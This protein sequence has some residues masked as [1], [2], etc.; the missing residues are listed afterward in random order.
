MPQQVR[1]QVTQQAGNQQAGKQDPSPAD[2]WQPRTALQLVAD[3]LAGVEAF[4]QSRRIAEQAA[5]AADLAVVSREARLDLSRRMT[6]LHREREALLAR[7]AQQMRDSA[8]Q[9]GGRHRA[10]ALLAHRNEW[11]RGKVADSLHSRGVAVVAGVD[12]GADAVG[13]M[14]MEQPDLVFLED[15]LPTMTG[16]EVL[17]QAA[18]LVPHARVVAQ[19][20]DL[21]DARLYLAAGA[22]A[23]LGRATSPQDVAEQLALALRREAAAAG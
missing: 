1:Q 11:L 21:R 17:R 9:L 3:Q 15:R 22:C 6:A 8:R 12:D 10:R 2:C 13:V 19:L 18:D 5:R 14:V 7:A 16:L 4:H 23:V 20:L